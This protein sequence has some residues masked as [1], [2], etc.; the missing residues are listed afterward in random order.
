MINAIPAAGSSALFCCDI[1]A[2]NRHFA[3]LYFQKAWD[4]AVGA[5]FARDAKCI[6]EV[7]DTDMK[8]IGT[9]EDLEKVIAGCNKDTSVNVHVFANPDVKEI[10]MRQLNK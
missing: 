1:G 6:V 4:L 9:C 8:K 2:G 5:L 10:V 3:L 7:V